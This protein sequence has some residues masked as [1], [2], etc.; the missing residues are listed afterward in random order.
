MIGAE[1]RGR[2]DT[3][4]AAH[5]ILSPARL[6]IPPLRHAKNNTINQAY[7]QGVRLWKYLSTWSA[8]EQK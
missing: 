2:T 8:T 1:G 3:S 7:N 4:L 6:P 5:W